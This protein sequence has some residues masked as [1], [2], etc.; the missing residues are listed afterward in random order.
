[1]ARRVPMRRHPWYPQSSYLFRRSRL[2]APT[3]DAMGL[4]SDSPYTHGSYD[5]QTPYAFQPKHTG[6]DGGGFGAAADTCGIYDIQKILIGQLPTGIN[7]SVPVIGTV[8]VPLGS[9]VGDLAKSFNDAALAQLAAAA[10]LGAGKAAGFLAS[11]V[12]SK[13]SAFVVAKYKVNSWLVNALTTAVDQAA[14]DAFYS[15]GQAI[16]SCRGAVSLTP[17][18][19]A[20]AQAAF[21]APSAPTTSPTSQGTT[22][23][24]QTDMEKAIA[25]ARAENLKH[26]GAMFPGDSFDFNQQIYRQDPVPTKPT[27]AGGGATMVL[28]GGAALAALM[29]LR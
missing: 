25:A 23:G 16:A 7:I 5:S 9:V 18:Q 15:V 3:A 4:G 14:V 21:N 11:K 2:H 10:D 24:Y 1:M 22:V 19:L 6:L 8:L 12:T 26:S 28:L 27:A 17:E 13:I 20:A 29:L